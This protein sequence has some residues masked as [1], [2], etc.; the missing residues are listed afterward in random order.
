VETDVKSTV[1]T[2]NGSILIM[3]LKK[4]H[5]DEAVA[6]DIDS[7]IEQAVTDH[8]SKL[9]EQLDQRIQKQS[10]DD[11]AFVKDT[12]G[13]AFRIAGG[14]VALVVIVLGALGW[15]N[16]AEIQKEMV[17]AAREKAEAQFVSPEGKQVIDSAL[18]QSVLNSYLTQ[19]ELLKMGKI[20][21]LSIDDFDANRLLRIAKKTETDHVTFQSAVRVL[22]TV[23]DQGGSGTLR[24]A[25]ASNIYDTFADFIAAKG[26]DGKWLANNSQKRMW[27]LNQ[28]SE[29]RFNHE[30]LK[31]AY[32][33]LVD[34][35]AP[36][37]LRQAVV[38]NIGIIRDSEGL[39]K[40]I[41]LVAPGSDLRPDALLAI[42]RIENDNKTLTNWISNLDTV[43]APSVDEI[44]SALKISEVLQDSN[45]D[46]AGK[47]IQ[48]A[49]RHSITAIPL[50]VAMLRKVGD[51]FPK[52][53]LF[54]L[55]DL[56]SKN[57]GVFPLAAIRRGGLWINAV[58]TLLK[59]SAEQKD[60]KDFQDL[61]TWLLPVN[62]SD[63]KYTVSEAGSLALHVSLHDAVMV[64]DN[65]KRIDGYLL[66]KGVSLRPERWKEQTQGEGKMWVRS[67][68][69]V[70][71]GTID[72]TPARFGLLSS[73]EKAHSLEILNEVSP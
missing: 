14:A 34:T 59:E 11:R 65:G 69:L 20:T 73:L 54:A 46:A 71:W 2:T 4:S 67:N 21:G 25:L 49:A 26:R 7:K 55:T 37:A 23:L 19:M 17:N 62:E 16:L 36:L 72:G 1:L 12:V 30:L 31:S 68:G 53:L 3:P 27:L 70:V 51:P 50:K 56:K 32:R 39:K 6:R 42:A 5:P 9:H 18:D 48:F 28:L 24:L 45:D 60:L 47:L 44:V 63:L 22:I 41:P 52:E 8:I 35:S 61:V 64:L 13:V 38:K 57:L 58:N 43:A 33:D 66:P 29:T 10:L 15:K 40:L